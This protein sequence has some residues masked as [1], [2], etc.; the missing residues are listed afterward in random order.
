MILKVSQR[1]PIAN[2]EKTRL[3]KLYCKFRIGQATR[4]S[5]RT[6]YQGL[7]MEEKHANYAMGRLVERAEMDKGIL[8]KQ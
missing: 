1:F 3:R 5:F 8:R 2:Q 7:D 4:V 6:T